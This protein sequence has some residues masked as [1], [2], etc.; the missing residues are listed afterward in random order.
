MFRSVKQRFDGRWDRVLCG[1]R[2][3]N[4]SRGECKELA[5]RPTRRRS[6][7]RV[8]ARGGVEVGAVLS[9][10]ILARKGWRAELDLGRSKPLDDAHRSAADGADV[11]S[12]SGCG[13]WS[14]W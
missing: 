10:G 3:E 11:E 1:E 4:G 13:T 9:C 6:Q 2:A 5:K 7:A 14:R 12:K 8:E